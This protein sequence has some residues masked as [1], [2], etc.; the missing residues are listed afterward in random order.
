MRNRRELNAKLSG[1]TLGDPDGD[2]EDTIKWVKK[3]KKREKE[4]ARKRQQEL[5]NMDKAFQGE[6]Y[7]EGMCSIPYMSSIGP[8]TTHRAEDLV[9]LKVS[10]DLQELAEG[11]THILTLKDSRILDGDGNLYSGSIYSIG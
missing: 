9:G 11:G 8:L 10:H 4:L 1:P 6:K 5:E 7:T 2:A 3:A